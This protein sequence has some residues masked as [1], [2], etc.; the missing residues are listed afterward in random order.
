MTIDPVPIIIIVFFSVIGI[1]A[2]QI[3]NPDSLYWKLK[4]KKCCQDYTELE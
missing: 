1:V 4:W 2:Y 3:M